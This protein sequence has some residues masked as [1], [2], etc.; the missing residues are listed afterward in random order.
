MTALSPPVGGL[1]TVLARSR[2]EAVI[3]RSSLAMQTTDVGIL[4][5][6]P[7]VA[8]LYQPMPNNAVGLIS[9]APSGN[10]R[11]WKW[12]FRLFLAMRA[13]VK[14]R[15][16]QCCLFNNAAAPLA[17]FAVTVEKAKATVRHDACSH[18]PDRGSVIGERRGISNSA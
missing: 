14:R 17:R 6:G 9:V 15:E 11:S 16:G 3:W 12:R 18:P 8:R 13:P 2:Q 7:A 5:T 10:N 1:D 4:L